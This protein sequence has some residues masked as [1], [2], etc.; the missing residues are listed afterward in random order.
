MPR[1]G[2][3]LVGIPKPPDPNAHRPIA[4]AEAIVQI[5][6]AIAV[7]RCSDKIDAFSGTSGLVSG[8]VV[9]NTIRELLERHPDFARARTT[10]KGP[11]QQ[12]LLDERGF[13]G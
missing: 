1:G 5:S 11:R 3:R 2:A 6:A 4:V 9:P 13:L 10:P 12:T 7:S 8:K